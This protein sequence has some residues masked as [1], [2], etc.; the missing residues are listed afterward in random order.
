MEEYE[1]SRTLTN[2][3]HAFSPIFACVVVGIT[4][5][6][7]EPIILTLA[8]G[9]LLAFPQGVW[10]PVSENG[11]WVPGMPSDIWHAADRCVALVDKRA[12][13]IR[14]GPKQVTCRIGPGTA[15]A[16][17]KAKYANP[18]YLQVISNFHLQFL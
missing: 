17:T 15:R 9:D 7:A 1:A 8:A 6:L 14:V 13:L 12:K 10:G 2:N 4:I 5:C 11:I 16:K 3:G 18:I